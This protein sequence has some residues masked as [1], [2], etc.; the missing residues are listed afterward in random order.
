ME[1][2]YCWRCDADVS[3]FDEVEWARL[4]PLLDGGIRAI[5]RYREDTGA[6][7]A[8]VPTRDLYS[9]M[10]SEHQRIA[11]HAE[12]RPQDV[13]H[14]RRSMHGP[15]CQRCGKPLR[16]PEAKQCAACGLVVD[17]V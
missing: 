17:A 6:A 5:K 2:V 3:M 16:T 4:A 14:H 13:W 7:L 12:V 8:D 15:P 11:G 1:T 9:S 10:L